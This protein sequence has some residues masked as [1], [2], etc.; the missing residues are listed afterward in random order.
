MSRQVLQ[1]V[2]DFVQDSFCF[3]LNFLYLQGFVFAR[4]FYVT[5]RSG[6]LG[7]SLLDGPVFGGPRPKLMVLN[8]LKR[9]AFCLLFSLLGLLLALS[10][11]LQEFWVCFDRVEGRRF[12]FSLLLLFFL[13]FVV[14][15]ISP[16]NLNFIYSI[17]HSKSNQAVS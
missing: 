12:C 10:F 17:N 9:F 5:C 15:L 8:G 16:F 7:R 2:S 3:C 11:C 6:P 13:N 1:Y 14:N 4:K